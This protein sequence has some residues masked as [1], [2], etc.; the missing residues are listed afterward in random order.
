MKEKLIEDMDIKKI[1][2]LIP[3]P[4]EIEE[5]E[6]TLEIILPSR[7]FNKILLIN[8]PDGDA[9]LFNLSTAK[10][11]RYPNYPAYGLGILANHLKKRGYNVQILNLNNHLFSVL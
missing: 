8:P 3:I 6:T 10:L 5:L 9:N 7:Q 11:C 1:S 2:T 4:E